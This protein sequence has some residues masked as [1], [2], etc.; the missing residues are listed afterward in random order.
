MNITVSGTEKGCGKT[1]IVSGLASV[2]QS[3]GYKTSVYKPVQTG[4]IDR[5][6]YLISPDLAFVKIFDK[7]IKTHASYMLKSKAIP[8]LGAAIEETDISL[9]KILQDYNV[10]E[11]KSDIV[12]TELTGGLMTPLNK[13]LY[14]FQLPLAM[15]LPVLFVVTPGV[16]NLNHLLNEINTAKT[17]GLNIAGVIVNKYPPYSELPE[18]KAFP[19]LIEEYSDA[20]V[21]GIVRNFKGKSVESNVL[22]NEIL[23]GIDIEDVFAMTIPKLNNN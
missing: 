17:T 3:L 7:Y 21:L 4:A 22:F 5:N 2:M 1:V 23:N 8:S 13:G 14:S 15:K 20:K 10:L 6:K 11:K 19:A 12:I 16:D 9:E 18:V